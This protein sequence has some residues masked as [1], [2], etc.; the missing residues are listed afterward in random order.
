MTALSKAPARSA[1]R[2]SL[3]VALLSAA[4]LVGTGAQLAAQEREM[5]PSASRQIQRLLEE[6]ATRTPA[7][8]KIGSDLLLDQRSTRGSEVAPDVPQLRSEV[9]VAPGGETLVDIKGEVTEALMARIEEVGG[10]VVNS[11]P[12][13][14]SVRAAVPIDRLEEIAELDEVRSIRS[15][16][17]YQLHM[18]NVSQGD[19]AHR[20]DV[21]R[22]AFG[23]DGTGVQVGVIS[24]SVE[25]LANLQ[26]SFD[27]PSGVQILTGQAGMGTSEGTA[28]LEIVPDLAPGAELLFATANG[29]QAQFAQNILD[30]RAAGADII[31]DDVSYFAEP[32]F[33]DG[34]IAEAVAQVI[35]DG[36]QYYSSAGNSG[37]FNDGTSGVWEGDFAGTAPPLPLTGLGDAHDFGGGVNFNEITLDSPSLFTLQ[38]SDPHAGSGNDYDLFLLNDDLTQVL[39][40]STDVQ[41]GDDDPFEAISSRTATGNINDTGNVLVVLRRPGAEVRHLHLNTNRGRIEI[42][43]GG[44]TSGHSAVEGAFSVAAV[45]VAVAGGGTFIGGPGNPVER[46]SSDGPRR[47]FFAGD[48]MEVTPGDLLATGGTVRDKPDIAAADGVSTATP[49]FDPFFGTSAA[50]PHAAAIG[51]LALHRDPSLTPAGIR[52]VYAATALD[53]EATGPDHDSGVGVIDAFAVLEALVQ[54]T[55]AVVKSNLEPAGMVAYKV[56]VRNDGTTDA[57]NVAITET[58]PDGTVLLSTEGCAED[59]AGVPICTLGTIPAGGSKEY[60]VNVG[61]TSREAGLLDLPPVVTIDR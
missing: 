15:A 7:Q 49:G 46:F 61:V 37:N 48:G 35:A 60:M 38:W 50:A 1:R 36:A 51:A 9:E 57:A 12:Q 18:I 11:F 5:A 28:M 24:D 20:A 30:L 58:L 59:K 6:K 42:A 29:G 54:P 43:T 14:G 22:A 3:R 19:V 39:A 23:V 26:T 27:L 56:T 2:W 16:E 13:Y 33:Q 41:D 25:A 21:A 44:Q 55:I 34:I 8:Q 53:I 52:A 31:V 45:N 10:E 17:E 47:I 32:V 4:A 40:S